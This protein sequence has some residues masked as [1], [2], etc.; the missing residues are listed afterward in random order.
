MNS[1]FKPE[2]TTY[3]QKYCYQCDAKVNYLFPDGRCGRCTRYTPEE[4]V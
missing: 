2:W 4:L 3:I 1:E